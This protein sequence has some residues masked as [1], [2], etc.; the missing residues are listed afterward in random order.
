MDYSWRLFQKSWNFSS[1][2]FGLDQIFPRLRGRNLSFGIWAKF[3]TGL[4]IPPPSKSGKGSDVGFVYKPL[5]DHEIRV[6]V[7]QP[8]H[9]SEPLCGH[10]QHTNLSWKQYPGYDALSYVWGHPSN[11]SVLTIDGHESSITKNLEY[12]LRHLRSEVEPITLW[13]DAVCINQSDVAERNSQVRRM[14]LIYELAKKVNIWLGPATPDSAI[15]IEILSYLATHKTA[16]DNPPWKVIP[17]YLV[18]AGLNDIMS[19]ECMIKFAEISPQWEQA[20]L[21]A[22]DMSPLLDLLDLQIGRQLERGHGGNHRHPRD[23][24]DVVHSMRHKISTDPRDKVFSLLGV[25]VTYE[26]EDFNVDYDMTV[27][28]TYLHLRSVINLG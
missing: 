6:F 15:G 2:L 24:L 22:I 4:V 5:D 7:L 13:I 14:G 27:E 19:R 1:S 11:T 25:P 28:E 23:L 8:G 16:A 3:S 18:K 17:S 21:G 26:V 9:N 10:L 12:A 20:G